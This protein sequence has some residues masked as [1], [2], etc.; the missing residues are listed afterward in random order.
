MLSFPPQL[1]AA[2]QGVDIFWKIPPPPGEER[3]YRLISYEEKLEKGKEKQ[4][5]K[6]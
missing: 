5:K 6:I 4:T 3:Q 2:P 1:I